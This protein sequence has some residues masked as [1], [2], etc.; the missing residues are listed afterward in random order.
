M[1]RDFVCCLRLL[2]DSMPSMLRNS[3]FLFEISRV[4]FG[5]PLSLFSFREK[6]KLGLISD[7]SQFYE[8]SNSNALDRIS[9]TTDINSMHMRLLNSCIARTN[10]LSF[11]DAG[12]GSGHL[13]N[14]LAL[15]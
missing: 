3:R 11:L 12:C 7:L 4:F 5:M 10:P 13:L 1:K 2:V 6:Y 8:K 14:A 15:S 9:S